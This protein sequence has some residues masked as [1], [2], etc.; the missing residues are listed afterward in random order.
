VATDYANPAPSIPADQMGTLLDLI[1]GSDS[2]ELK[3]SVP[4]QSQR[5]TISNLPL[6][7]VE[8]QP[9]QIFFFETPDLRLNQAGVV[10]RARRIQGGRGDTVVKLRPVVPDELPTEVR[11]SP[12]FNVEVDALPGGFVCSGS[13]KGRSTGQEIRDAVGGKIPLR[14]IFTREQRA[15][16]KAHAPADLTFETLVPLGPTFILK[17]VFEPKGFDRRLVAEMW[18]YPDGSRILELSTKCL[19]KEAFQVAAEVRAYLANRGVPISGNQQTKT[20]TALEYF[21]AELRPVEEPAPAPASGRARGPGGRFVKAGATPGSP[22][23]RR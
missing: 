1:R 23:P 14:K 17:A 2:V 19:P 5:A 11:R 3:L 4:A 9:R 15:F 20:K 6:D 16:F 7:P 10:V 18:L 22:A 12:S 21:A 8:A 13:M